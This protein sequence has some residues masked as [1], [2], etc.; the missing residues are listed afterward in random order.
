MSEELS[1][2]TELAIILGAAGIFTVISKA[3]KQPLILGYIVAGFLVGP[4]LGLFPQFS[5]SSVHQWS[6]IGIIFL[7][8]SLGLEFSFKRLLQIGSSALITAG[9]QCIGML[10]VGMLAGTAMG[11]SNMES[12][13]LGGLM[14]MSSTT[15]IIKAYD[16][17]GIKNRPYSGLLFGSLVFQDLIAVLLMVLLSTLAV[18]N[19][20]EGI[21]MLMAIAKLVFF[22]ILWFLVGIYVIPSLLK[23]A[24][25]Y[26]TDEILLLVSIGLCFLMVVLA[27]AVGFSS[28]LGAFVM[29]SILSSTIEG[30]HIGHIT[31]HIKDLFGAIFFVSVGMMVDPVVIAQ[32][33]PTILIITLVAMLGILVFSSTG[34]LLAGKGLNSALHIGFSLAQL[35]EFSFIIASLGCSM[36]VLRDFIY[37]V[38]IAVSVITTFT[39]PYMIKAATPV[40]KWVYKVLPGSILSK[41]DPPEKAEIKSSLAARSEWKSFLLNFFKRTGLYG[42]M[43]IALLLGSRLFLTKIAENIFVDIPPF[44]SNLLQTAVTIAFMAPFLYG[45]LYNTE[46]SKAS[47]RKLMDENNLNKWPILALTVGRLAMAVFFVMMAIVDHFDLRGWTVLLSVIAIVF[48]LLFSKRTMHRFGN[49]ETRFIENLN[50]KEMEE[51]RHSPVTSA[52]KEK[53]SGYDVHLEAVDISPNYEFI[54]KPLRE[55]PFRH[56]SG[57]N[58][59]KIQRGKRSII[60]P[61]GDEKIYP[62][63]R[64]LAVG[65]TEQIN[66]FL[67][68]IAEGTV[69]VQ[70]ENG[71]FIVDSFVLDEKSSL[72]GR[73]LRDLSMRKSGCTVISVMRGDNLVTNPSADWSFMTGDIVW[74][75]G[76]KDSLKWYEQ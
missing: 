51:K 34:V 14:S 40:T 15:I 44:L 55:M 9:T 50:K 73:S 12:I 5:A 27:N 48:M 8:F 28:A 71:D 19:K 23:K 76:L 11:W 41:I 10:I 32:Y 64:L 13:F 21:Q 38:V 60:I 37:P 67:N 2:V 35:G 58:I 57:V 66:S 29:G 70:S 16:D 46:S 22:L 75:A 54:G 62:G 39:T 17:L 43:L 3:L 63:D 18:S 24:R 31:I 26:L 53:L 33:W 49:L 20:F 74:M 25:K 69:E 65:T 47:A 36:G 30:E 61:S 6:E 4:H 56:V 72:T 45:F 52:V 59:V 68:Y 1:L 7:L 42:V